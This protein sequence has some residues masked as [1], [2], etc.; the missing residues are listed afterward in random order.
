MDTV[1]RAVRE[2]EIGATANISYPRKP[3]PVVSDI[4]VILVSV[5]PVILVAPV[6]ADTAEI[7]SVDSISRAT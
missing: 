3:T 2:G 7:P 5:I 4:P 1:D 6:V